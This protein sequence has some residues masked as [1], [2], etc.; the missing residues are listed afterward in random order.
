M[1]AKKKTVTGRLYYDY[2]GGTYIQTEN[3]SGLC[4]WDFWSDFH[5]GDCSLSK[6][7]TITIEE[8]IP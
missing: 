3:G 6:L 2:D 8:A 4:L 5:D 7:V 1:P